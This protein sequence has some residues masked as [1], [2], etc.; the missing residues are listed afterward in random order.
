MY[1]LECVRRSEE[2][3]Y[4]SV[5]GS[6]CD[7]EWLGQDACEDAVEASA[8]SSGDPWRE[9]REQ[10]GKG[11]KRA[12]VDRVLRDLPLGVEPTQVDGFEVDAV[13]GRGEGE[14]LHP[15]RVSACGLLLAS[16]YCSNPIGTAMPKNS[17][18]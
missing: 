6:Q 9:S 12:N 8:T 7:G 17:T 3:G 13:N 4:Q 14:R 16:Y 5:G 15:S 11:W 18:S 2:P 10:G 1:L